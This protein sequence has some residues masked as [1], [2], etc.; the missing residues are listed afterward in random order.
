MKQ[1]SQDMTVT[2]LSLPKGGG[3]ISGMGDTISN[4][5]PDGMAS[6]SVPLPI[7]AGRGSAPNLSLN[8]SSGAGNG[9]FGIGW[10]SSTMAISRRTQHGVPQYHGED[11]F[12]CPMGEVMAVAVNQSGQPDVRKTDKLLGGQLPVTYT[13]TR[14]QPR[15][16]QHFSK[17]E[18]W[19]PPTDVK[20]TPFWLMYSPDGQIHIFG[21]TEQA[22]IANPAE[23][24][25][26]AQ[27]LLEETVTPTGE[28]IYYQYRAEDDIG[29]DD[30]EKNSHLN[31]SA[32]R[33]LTQVN[34]GNITPEPSL[35]VLK[36]TPP[37]DN[38]WLFHL[39]FDYGERAQEINTVPPFKAPSNNWKIRPDRF[40]RFEYGFEVRTRRLCQQILMFHRLKSLTGEQI[41]GE[42]TP[43]LVAR[44]LLSYDLNNSVTTLTAIR[45]MAYETDATLVALPPLEFDYQ[46]FEAKVTQKWQEMPQLAG[47]NAQQPYQLVD[48]YGE[49][50]SGI[51]YQDRPGAWWYQ[52][53]IRQKNVEDINAVTYSPI[54]PLPKIPSQ[55]DRATLMDIDG[56]GHLDWVIA[57]AGIQGRY[58]MQPNGEWTHFIPISAL[59]T[60]YFHPQAQLADL[61]G[62][63]LS[64]LALI[65]PRSVR[66]YANDRGN[67]KAGINVM[68]PDGVNLPIFGGDASSLVAF[69][70][71]LGSGQP[72]LVEIAAQSVKCW[73]NLGHGRF[74]AAI[75]LP[76]FSQPNGTFNANQVFLADIDGSGTA[77]IIYAHSTYLDIYLNESGNRFSAPVQLALPEGVM[78]DNTCQLQVSDIQ[79]L[80]A[81]SIVLTVPHMT[82]RHWRY[83]FTYNKPWL[84]NV[85]NNNRGAETTL[86][87]RS[88][89][90]FWLDEKSQIE[91]PG[92][93]AA[94]YLPFPIH[95][96]WR[97]EVLDE[98]TGNRLT[99]VMNYAHGAWDGRER[100]FCGFG[101]VTQ[102][103]TDEFAKGT[104]EK[105]PD[106]NIY[107]SRSISWFATGLPEV[108]SQL[109]AEY[110]RGD[111][112]AFAGFTPRFTR[113]EKADAGQAGQDTPIKEP[114]ETEAYW[115]NRAMKGQL[116]RSEVYG[117]D[118]TEKAKIPYTVTEAR[119]QVRLIPSNDEA[120]PSSWTS[121]IENRS[122]HYERIVVDPSCKQQVVLKADEYGFPLAK[123]D[124]AYPR[125]NKPAQNPYPDSLPDTLF[126]DSYDDQQKQLYLTK[127]Q[128]SYYHLTQQDDWVLGLTDSR[129]SEVYHYAQTDAQ[130]DIPK[131][132]LTLEDLLK[133]DGL[134]GKDKAFIYLGQQRV[135]Y[136]G[137]D[138]EKPTRQVRVAY[139]ETAAFDDN[140]LHAFDGVIAPDELT[141]QLQAGGYLLVPQ[142]SDAAVS[143]GKVWV[144]R[145]GYTEYGDASQFYRPLIQRKS[146]LTGKYT[147]S[148]DTRYCVV[149]KT[150]DGAG[151]T[152]QAKYDYRFL[153]PAQLTDINDNQHIV[154]FNALGQV[155]SS[156]FW[157]TENGEMSGY[158]TPENKPF[159][160]P[161]TVEKAL[162]LKPTIPVSQCNIYVPDSWMRLL[163][164]QSLT[165][166]LKEGETLW[167]AL[168]RAGVVTEDG[169]ICELA[170]R[171][172]LNRQTLSSME[173]VTLQQILAQT[174]RQPPHAMTITT[175]RY[176]SDSQQQLRQSIALSDGFG[177]VLQSAQRHEAGDAWQRA[178]DGSLVVD[179]AGKPTVA[180]TT[181]RWAVSGRTEYDGKGQAIR[182]YLP[183]YLND[184]RY[185]SDDSARDDLYAD[186]HFYDPLGREYQ[187]KTA[188]GFWRENMFMPWFVVNEDENDTAA[189]LTS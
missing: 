47:L 133:V 86:F 43:A 94:S 13:V 151:M 90:Q 56:D 53:P 180:Y 50:I 149:V 130:S 84:L 34:Y 57:G 36:N 134:I 1:D 179:N 100:E 115:L 10:Q 142:I 148:W 71:M 87:Y 6:L 118:K 145:Q 99:K 37:A 14:H 2:Q 76:G 72:H 78:F 146:L 116:L 163:P 101:R 62:A 157:G 15:N 137:G 111:D 3:A 189:R 12:L 40:S 135:A 69:S 31:A 165:G 121:I 66:L 155:T 125:R 114:T 167:N 49:G 188:K 8:Y 175:D 110:W 166:Q 70:D 28:H 102:I 158:S 152:T 147:L 44:L 113:Y 150:E 136:V 63:G 117:D 153:L 79:G 46:P 120:A 124:I 160:V 52:A 17:L 161:D 25:Q 4:A 174:P 54:N 45:Q 177:R 88:S 20:T 171:R 154:T 103:D 61:V 140:A 92:K 39:V 183:Y 159:T 65:G 144:A 143:S 186:T 9:S 82:P 29:C 81:A 75:L 112:Q 60:E 168:H 11:T 126:A 156:R 108:D 96:L 95:L 119:C 35:L 132:G 55:Q 139:T 164:Q 169:L 67:W 24:S 173:A 106:E 33:Y 48:L 42:E 91:E 141:Q 38:E 170:C 18:Y 181:T 98:I 162:A 185:V 7:S 26:I 138:A 59:P 172:W 30:S 68:P 127:Q 19:Q 22:Q 27:W 83:D 16:I 105:A 51:L 107:P 187:V 104:T 122:Y 5:G 41:D 58:S 93:F 64:D 89:A 123:V 182:A 178:E 109:P 32:Q 129:Y 21:K 77:D 176:D 131:A 85:I 184:W 80:G 73:P 128:Q 23:A 74:G 97:N